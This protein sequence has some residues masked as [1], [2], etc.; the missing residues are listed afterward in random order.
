MTHFDSRGAAHSEY[1]SWGDLLRQC[2]QQGKFRGSS[3]E[4]G[5]HRTS[6]TGTDSMAHALKLAREGWPEGE[7]KVSA[8]AKRLEQALVHGIVREEQNYDVEGMTFDTARYLEGE[9]ECWVKIEES[10]SE[11]PHRNLCI[12]LNVAASAGVSARVLE[13]RGAATA[14]LVSLLE[15]AGTRVEVWVA[16]AWGNGTPSFTW[17]AKVKAYDQPIEPSRLAFALVSPSICRRFSF[18]LAEQL[19]QSLQHVAGYDNGYGQP[20]RYP[21]IPK[22][23]LY[24]DKAHLYES[25]WSS[26]EGA[27]AWI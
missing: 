22:D 23:A 26:T 27:L 10:T 11:G 15:Y 18:R 13:A 3:D 17:K 9:P 14:A 6:W 19:P 2:E 16:C 7:A 12:M 20:Q 5:A 21:H 8:L 1:Q 4:R 25:Q 24:I